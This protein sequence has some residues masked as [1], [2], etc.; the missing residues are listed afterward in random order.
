MKMIQ[1]EEVRADDCVLK[2]PSKIEDK[3]SVYREPH[4]ESGYQMD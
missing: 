4:W 2:K 1:K 3:S